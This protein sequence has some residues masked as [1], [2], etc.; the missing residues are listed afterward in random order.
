MSTIASVLTHSD[1][2]PGPAP[3]HVAQSASNRKAPVT[4]LFEEGPPGFEPGAKEL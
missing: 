4:G 3:E 1:V 2:P